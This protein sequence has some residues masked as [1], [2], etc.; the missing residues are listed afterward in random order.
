MKISAARETFDATALEY[1]GRFLA[2]ARRL[3]PDHAA[4]QDVVQDAMLSAVRNLPRFRGDSQMSTWLG[5]I[6]INS[7]LTRRR[8]IRRRP[9]QSIETLL[10]QPEPKT[11]QSTPLAAQGPSPEGVLL[12]GEVRE[13]LRA[14]VEQLPEDYRRVVVMRHFEESRITDIAARLR[15][16][17][18]AAKLRLLRAHRALRRL[19]EKRGYERGVAPAATPSRGQANPRRG[20]SESSRRGWGPAASA[21]KVA[22]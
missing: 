10:A 13:L 8:V 1:R 21:N 17:P 4:A 19:L 20:V 16:T 12:G 15:I 11:H 2:T 7:A 14:A 9:E 18:N 22:A 5:R 3:L 6:V